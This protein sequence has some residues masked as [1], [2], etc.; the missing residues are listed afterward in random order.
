[1]AV[2]GS[3]VTVVVDKVRRSVGGETWLDTPDLFRKAAGKL[4]PELIGT[5][6]LKKG[7]ERWFKED[8]HG[9]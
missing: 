5:D 1:M 4:A 7:V 6:D 3:E 2:T 8:S 9:K